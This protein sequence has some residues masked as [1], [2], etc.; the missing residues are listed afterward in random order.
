MGTNEEQDWAECL[1]AASME[2]DDS[3]ARAMRA[4]AVLHAAT[5]VEQMLKLSELQTRV[6]TILPKDKQSFALV[7]RQRISEGWLGDDGRTLQNR[8]DIGHAIDTRNKIAHEKL[9]PTKGDAFRAVNTFH[10]V[11][12]ILSPESSDQVPSTSVLDSLRGRISDLRGRVHG[13]RGP[14]QYD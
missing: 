11:A 12:L 13:L 10:R 8:G 7:L 1:S 14:H 4:Q 2:G 3:G 5:T 9:Q 6:A